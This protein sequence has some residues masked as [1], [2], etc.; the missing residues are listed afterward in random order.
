M[1]LMQFPVIAEFCRPQRCSQ[2]AVLKENGLR[3]AARQ[4]GS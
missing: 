3:S 1:I 4:P 2:E